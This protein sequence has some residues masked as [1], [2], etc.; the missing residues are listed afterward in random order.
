MYDTV[1]NAEI[2]P[3]PQ[4]SSSRLNIHPRTKA[5]LRFETGIRWFVDTGPAAC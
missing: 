5:E 3:W 4:E 1:Q 2:V